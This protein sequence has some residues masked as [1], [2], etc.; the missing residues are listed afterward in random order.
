[1]ME[2]NAGERSIDVEDPRHES[3]QETMVDEA[4]VRTV[5]EELTF[6]REQLLRTAAELQNYRR[7]TE[8]VRSAEAAFARAAVIE[9]F[10]GVL[11]DLERTL[12]AAETNQDPSATN[13]AAFSTLRE[14]VALV[15]RKF[16]DELSRMGVTVI[17]SVG[18]RFDES[19]HEALMQQPALEGQKPGT[20]VSEVQKGYRLGDRVLRHARVIVAA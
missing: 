17:P 5:E 13:N 18:E 1:M 19:L 10:L 15:H 3:S 7:R 16:V 14:G 12:E 20:V 4:P 2:E 6:V 11:D 8:Q 9:P